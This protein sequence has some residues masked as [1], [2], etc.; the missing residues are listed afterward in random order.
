[1]L[2]TLTIAG[3]MSLPPLVLSISRHSLYICQLLEDCLGNGCTNNQSPHSVPILR[4][5]SIYLT[6][7]S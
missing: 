3:G 7:I 2:L 1:M 4:E 5:L 6:P